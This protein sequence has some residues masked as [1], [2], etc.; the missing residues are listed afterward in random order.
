[1]FV[2]LKPKNVKKTFEGTAST[3]SF[4]SVNFAALVYLSLSALFTSF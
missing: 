1:M 2:F 3:R 4:L